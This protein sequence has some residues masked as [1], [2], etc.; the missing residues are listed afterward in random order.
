MS[1]YC[2]SAA[3]GIVLGTVHLKYIWPNFHGKATKSI[4]NRQ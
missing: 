4:F 1:G 3:T 2:K